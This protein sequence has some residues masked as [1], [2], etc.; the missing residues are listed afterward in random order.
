VGDAFDRIKTSSDWP[1]QPVDSADLG[2]ALV[3]ASQLMVTPVPVLEV[4]PR[5]NLSVLSFHSGAHQDFYGGINIV[6]QCFFQLIATVTIKQHL[7]SLI[8]SDVDIAQMVRALL[9]MLR[10]T[11]GWLQVDGL[12]ALSYL[13]FANM[14]RLGDFRGALLEY[15][16]PIA[17]EDINVADKHENT[18]MRTERA[19]MA[20]NCLGNMCVRSSGVLED[21]APSIAWAL[22]QALQ[23]YSTTAK[24]D[25]RLT[26]TLSCCLRAIQ[27]AVGEGIVDLEA[28][29]ISI[30]ATLRTVMA[31]GVGVEV[32]LGDL[33][34]GPSQD[35]TDNSDSGSYA[36]SSLAAF[37]SLSVSAAPN[38]GST[39]RA[40]GEAMGGPSW[41]S[42]VGVSGLFS[43]SSSLFSGGFEPALEETD[44]D[45]EAGG[46][47]KRS[48]APVK[49][50]QSASKV[51]NYALHCIHTICK[52]HPKVITIRL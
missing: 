25:F 50:S 21:H 13:I 36:L 47:E 15:L 28:D 35:E 9:A 16:L 48:R 2:D 52:A 43:S 6:W 17:K 20:I 38:A 22:L 10:V 39:K 30:I 41:G 44:F 7:S 24:H 5:D 3:L 34:L 32:D 37:G 46:A 33:G 29:I 31:W 27:N 11:G 45:S 42:S 51:R 12:R 40:V 1:L 26:S 19:R 4:L 23:R 49:Y 8:F 14:S 18:Y